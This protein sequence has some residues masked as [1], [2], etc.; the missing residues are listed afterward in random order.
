MA[1]RLVSKHVGVA[2][3]DRIHPHITKEFLDIS[4]LSHNSTQSRHYLPTDSMRSHSLRVK[5][6]KI[7]HPPL[8]LWTP[9]TSPGYHMYF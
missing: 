2:V 1:L 8:P 3:R 5:S 4:G 7:L 9:V 6:Y